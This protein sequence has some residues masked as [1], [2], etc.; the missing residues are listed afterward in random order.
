[1]SADF[2]YVNV[3]MAFTSQD[4][5]ASVRASTVINY[6]TPILSKADDWYLTVSRL[7]INNY[8]NP[9]IVP[10]VQI[11]QPDPNKTVYHFA[12]GY[13]GFYSDD[14]YVEYT[15][16]SNESL[17]APPIVTQDISTTYYYCYS[18]GSFLNMWNVALAKALTSLNSK[19]ATGV[20]E[21]PVFYFDPASGVVLKCTQQYG[22]DFSLTPTSNKIQ[23]YC[24]GFIAPLVNGIDLIYIENPTNTNYCFVLIDQ[25]INTQVI[26][27]TTYWIIRQQNINEISNWTTPLVYQ[28]V[29]NT[30]PIMQ[31]YNNSPSGV[32]GVGQQST[33]QTALLTDFIANADVAGYHDN[34]LYNKVDSLRM[35]S[36]TSSTGISSIDASVYILDQ[37][38][39]QYPLLLGPGGSV[40]LKLEFIKK[41]VYKGFIS[42][43]K[44]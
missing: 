37:Y 33:Q 38:G 32:F 6:G 10:L 1:M 21:P 41:D 19:T 3:N 43:G 28:I 8:T 34:Q 13:N 30:L 25:V 20:T 17:P 4:Q 24:G 14:I 35:I 26:N 31:E 42:S 12:L 5:N 15:P 29:S 40:Q 39:R 16:T 36:M 22:Q 7:S 9:L 11:G 2:L 44:K 18:Y 27:S 23:I